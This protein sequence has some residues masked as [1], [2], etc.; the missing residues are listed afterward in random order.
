MSF[1]AARHLDI[2][3]E[4]QGISDFQKIVS[5]GIS[6]DLLKWKGIEATEQLAKSQNSNIVIVGNSKDSLPVMLSGDC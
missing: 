4:A 3:I 6:G 1:Q 2:K 5:Q